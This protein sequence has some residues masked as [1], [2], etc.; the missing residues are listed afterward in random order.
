VTLSQS[1][2]QDWEVFSPL[3]SGER[4]IEITLPEGEWL[5]IERSKMKKLIALTAFAGL[6]A[7][8]C[9]SH[10]NRG[11]TYENPQANPNYGTGTSGTGTM[12]TTP[13]GQNNNSA[14]TPST[15]GTYNNN[16]NGTSNSGAATSPGGATSGSS[17]Q[18]QNSSSNPNQGSSNPNSDNSSNPNP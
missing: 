1:A 4:L 13:S 17:S 12:S 16:P 10:E 6:L 7:V 9:A 14:T 5:P 18:D 3:S 11:G 15:S 8:G 2:R